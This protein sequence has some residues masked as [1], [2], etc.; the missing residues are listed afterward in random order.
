MNEPA[1]FNQLE[2]VV[3]SFVSAI[4][5]FIAIVLFIMI[6]WGGFKYITS[7]GNPDAAAAARKTMTFAIAGLL[8]VASA[9][10]IIIIIQNITGA[11]ITNFELFLP[12]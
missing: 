3:G 2:D 12:N 7:G 4:M 1:N 10:L 8:V 11:G 5:G 9:Y 6:V